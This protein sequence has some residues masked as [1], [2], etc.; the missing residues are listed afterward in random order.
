MTDSRTLAIALCLLCGMHALA[1]AQ[2]MI[3]KSRGE[4]LYTTHCSACHASEIHW[5][6]QK[7]AMDWNSL[8][9]QVHKWQ[10]SI[11][12]NW[13]DDEIMD[14]ARYL[15]ALYYDFQIPERKSYSRSKKPVQV[16][17]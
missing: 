16:L 4:L 3:D 2:P 15:N 17:R 10:A 13:S 12:Q 11:G 6:K 5:C 8:V 7:L 1:H 14:V 9:D